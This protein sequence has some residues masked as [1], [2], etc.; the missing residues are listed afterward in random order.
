MK[1]LWSSRKF[2]AACAGLV[3]VVMTAFLPDFPQVDQQIADLGYLVSAYILGTGL[4]GGLTE[5]GQKFR[6]LLHSRKLWAALAGLLT[7]LLRTLV[8]DF[9]LA[10]EQLNAIILTLSAYILGTGAQDGLVNLRASRQ[11][12]A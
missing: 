6:E 12:Q 5:P 4:E 2:W 8:P 3:L 1:N 11:G 10:D 7:L 9:P